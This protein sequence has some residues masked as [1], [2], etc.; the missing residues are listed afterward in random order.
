MIKKNKLALDINSLGRFSMSNWSNGKISVG[1]IRDSKKGNADWIK[2]KEFGLKNIMNF[3]NK[4][5]P[6]KRKQ[7]T[8][9]DVGCNDG[10]LTEKFASLKFKKVLG[11]EPRSS[12]ILRGKKIRKI[13]KIKSKSKYFCKTI[14]GIGRDFH[15]DIVVSSGVLHHTEDLVNNFKK[16]LKISKKILLIEGEFVKED[17]IINKRNKK[18]FQAKDLIYD[19]VEKKQ[20]I[21]FSINKLESNYFDGSSINTGLVETPSI[22]KLLMIATLNNFKSIIY[23]KKK[24]KNSLNTYRAILIFERKPQDLEFKSFFLN[25]ELIFFNNILPFHILKKIEKNKHVG[26]IK[27]NKFQHKILSNLRYNKKDKLNFEYA[28]YFLREKNFSKAKFFL[29]KIIYKPKSDW[30]SCYRAF[31]LYN[32]IDKKN[33]LKWLQRLKS[34]NPNFPKK[35]LKNI[36]F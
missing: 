3:L 33:K 5:P 17:L 10:F 24:F 26:K 7:M 35:V 18:Y 32:F 14:E 22:S 8:L 16:L 34:S 30:F 11:S 23:K 28:K 20:K 4:I 19:Y 27:L 15:T 29:D 1:E 25:H 36:N 2:V 13:L 31:A 12:T 6:I 21:G 9:H